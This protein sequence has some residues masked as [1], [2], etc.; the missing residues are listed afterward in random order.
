MPS[1]EAHDGAYRFRL[2]VTSKLPTDLGY[3]PMSAEIDFAEL[4]EQARLPGVLDPNS[5]E[6]VDVRTGEI[7]PHARR[8]DF[9]YSDR[10]R[11]EW[12]IKDPTH[13]EYEI[14]FKTAEKRPPL[15]PQD[16]V[17]M[18]GTGDLLRYNAGE[19][20][21]ITLFHAMKLVDLTG[22]GRQ[23]LAGCWNYYYRPG[24]PISGVICYPR[25]GPEDDFTFGDLTR[26]PYVEQRGSKDYKDFPG[27]YVE[28]DF[29]DS[30]CL[31][32]CH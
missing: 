20:R 25:V 3:I 32:C 28:A 7:I 30:R 2:T 6:V 19:P 29:A 14:Q 17:P 12:V 22:D 9:A 8:E 10:G 31:H 18:I 11:I 4:I 16:Y 23:D 1:A 24:S 27:V 5:I 26:V 13:R 15:E 21:P